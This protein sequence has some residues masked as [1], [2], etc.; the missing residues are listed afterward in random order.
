[1]IAGTVL[2]AIVFAARTI[3]A[4]GA[5]LIVSFMLMLHLGH[6]PARYGT[7]PNIISSAPGAV[8]VGATTCGGCHVRELKLWT[9]SHHQLAM[10]PAVGSAV[11]GDFSAKSLTD[12]GLTSRFFR[13]DNKF[14]VRTEGPDGALHDYQIKYTFGVSPLQ[15][16]LIELPG[17]R[18]Q[19]FGVAWDSRAPDD[20]GQRWVSLHPGQKVGAGDPLH[21]SAIN[22]N[23]NFMCADCHSTNVR[24]NYRPATRTFA[25]SYAE[26]NVACEACHG[27]GSNHVAWAQKKGDWRRF[28]TNHGLLT[29]LDE[30]GGVT[31]KIDTVSGNANTQY[32]P[33]VRA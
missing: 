8:F 23:W 4:L 20:G 30:R 28:G 14:M 32:F 25:T 5:G 2:L 13:R 19:A 1:M 18:L 24:K 29:T 9:G 11:L 15:Q 10:Q 22:Q 31:W 21:W 3:S 26:I 12:R 27:P 6:R 7:N 16:Y 33:L 17:G